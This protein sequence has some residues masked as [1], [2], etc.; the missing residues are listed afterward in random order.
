MLLKDS[1]FTTGEGDLRAESEDGEAVPF[2][3]GKAGLF[4]T[5]KSW[6]FHALHSQAHLVKR[7]YRPTK[8]QRVR[9]IFGWLIA[10][11]CF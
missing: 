10:D 6:R 2:F 3:F 1:V 5:M 4:G 11:L 8:R 7:S 9:T